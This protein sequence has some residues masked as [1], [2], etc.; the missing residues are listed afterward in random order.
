MTTNKTEGPRLV[1]FFNKRALAVAMIVA[2]GGV[3]IKMNDCKDVT[4][5][6]LTLLG[7]YMA[8][9]QNFP[10]RFKAFLLIMEEL[11]LG[12]VNTNHCA[13]YSDFKLKF[14]SWLEQNQVP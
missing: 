10:P 12:R 7:C 14:T 6:I 9:D 1:L 3:S 4:T 8:W 2:D 13:G 5:V 11:G